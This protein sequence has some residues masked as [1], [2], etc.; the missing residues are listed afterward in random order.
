MHVLYSAQY[1]CKNILEQV[2]DIQFFG[3]DRKQLLPFI[4]C[5]STCI[6]CIPRLVCL[7]SCSFSELIRKTSASSFVF[8]LIEAKKSYNTQNFNPVVVSVAG[9]IIGRVSNVGVLN[10]F[11]LL[12]THSHT[13]MWGDVLPTHSKSGMCLSV[14]V[15]KMILLNCSLH[16]N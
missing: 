13:H 11:S 8:I 3:N 4:W 9:Y 6:M 10:I 7:S 5:I 14:S 15:A 16:S 12:H 1:M 2:Y